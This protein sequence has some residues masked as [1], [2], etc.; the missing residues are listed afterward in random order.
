MVTIRI[1]KYLASQGLASRRQ[2]DELI[3]Q[4]II[5]INGNLAKPGDKIDPIIDKIFIDNQEFIPVV[6]TPIYIMLHKPM[7]YVTTAFPQKYQKSVFELID[8][9]I[10]L[11]PVGRLDKNTTGLLLFTNDGELTYRLTH[12][13]FEKTKS[14]TVRHTGVK[15]DQ[16][17]HIA[18]GVVLDGAFTSPAKIKTQDSSQFEITIHEG[19]N[20]QIRRMCEQVGIELVSLHRHE[21]HGLFL[22][23][24]PL[25]RWR[26]LTKQEI[27]LLQH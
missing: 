24:L 11:F 19:R 15:V 21:F 8:N 10:R 17:Q 20:R 6:Q 1:N 7:D 22:G 23:D 26:Y 4:E 5:T 25:G 13:R 3:H 16:L 18:D 12:P 14:Y 2:V 27:I 9:S